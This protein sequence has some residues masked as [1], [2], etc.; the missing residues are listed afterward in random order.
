MLV[1]SFSTGEAYTK[2]KLFFLINQCLLFPPSDQFINITHASCN[3]V[4]FSSGAIDRF[5]PLYIPGR[6]SHYDF[7]SHKKSSHFRS[8]P[9][10]ISNL[11][12][13]PATGEFVHFIFTDKGNL[14]QPYIPLT[15]S[16]QGDR[17]SLLIIS[18]RG[19]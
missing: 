15:P 11:S 6:T 4:H 8:H 7:G 19:V 1:Y 14:L 18:G 16:V 12:R 3:E 2:L 10:Q 17:P 5:I 9:C 13:L